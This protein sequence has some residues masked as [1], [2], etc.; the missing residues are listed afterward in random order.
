MVPATT[1]LDGSRARAQVHARPATRADHVQR[2][3]PGA[4]ARAAAAARAGRQSRARARDRGRGAAACAGAA[5]AGARPCAAGTSRC[6]ASLQCAMCEPASRTAWYRNA[7]ANSCACRNCELVCLSVCGRAV[8][9]RCGAEVQSMHDLTPVSAA[10]TLILDLR[11][12]AAPRRR[13]RRGGR[14]LR[15]G[16][17]CHARLGVGPDQRAAGMTLHRAGPLRWQGRVQSAGR[18]RDLAPCHA[19]GLAHC[20]L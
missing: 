3:V 15:G 17:G 1:M 18:W 12:R 9:F 5:Y 4:A 8:L 10:V 13:G 11:L 19:A 20:G 7:C 16:G 2:R 14:R 6:G